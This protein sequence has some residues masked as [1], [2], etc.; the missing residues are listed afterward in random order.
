MEAQI[1]TRPQVQEELK[2]AY[3]RAEAAGVIAMPLLRCGL[4]QAQKMV[5]DLK[6]PCFMGCGARM[7]PEEYVKHEA[8]CPARQVLPGDD[9]M[10]TVPRIGARPEVVK[11]RMGIGVDKLEHHIQVREAIEEQCKWWNPAKLRE[12]MAAMVGPDH[13]LWKKKQCSCSGCVF[14]PHV[15]A[16][17]EARQKRLQQKFETVRPLL[18]RKAID[19]DFDHNRIEIKRP[20]NFAKRKPP[21]SSADFDEKYLDQAN[22]T[23]ADLAVV[24]KNYM[25]RMV[26]EGHT[27]GASDPISY[28][29]DLANNRA[30]LIVDTLVAKGVRKNLLKAIGE[31][32]G[33]A[34]VAVYPANDGLEEYDEEE[35]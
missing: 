33:G 6:F 10:I 2:D 28:W 21:D 27:G 4:K 8:V 30:Q 17:V 11:Y 31:P 32:G 16:A 22:D 23:I 35:S 1:D 34:K 7:T 12:A 18:P 29:Q 20:I 15:I 13:Y 19:I 3:K 24:I 5:P 25:E 9:S 14:P 26:V